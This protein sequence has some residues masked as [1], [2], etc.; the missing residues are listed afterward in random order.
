M[1]SFKSEAEFQ[2]L[3]RS[4]YGR[5]RRTLIGMT[6]NGAI[7]EELTQ[8]TFLKAWKGLPLFSRRSQLSTW[9]YQV[10][11]NTGR[12][13]LRTH[14]TRAPLLDDVHEEPENLE[15]QLALQEVEDEVR[16]LLVLHYYEGLKL[17]EIAA[18]LKVPEGTVKSRLY[19]AKGKLKEKLLSKGY[20]V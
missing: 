3:Y 19:N 16:E 18:V 9:L 6:G 17:T 2:A 7:A 10:A 1:I 8:E 11:I 20:D 12:D 15:L 4:H 14:K 5:I 13:W